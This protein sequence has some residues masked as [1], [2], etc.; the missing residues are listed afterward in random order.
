MT[1]VDNVIANH[2]PKQKELDK[3][4]DVIKRKIIRDYKLPTGRDETAEV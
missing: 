3:M 4:M 2:I 1:K